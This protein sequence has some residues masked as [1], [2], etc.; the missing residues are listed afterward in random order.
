MRKQPKNLI[1]FC[2]LF[3]VVLGLY[4]GL[5]SFA[6][7][8]SDS[9]KQP[10]TQ[11]STNQLRQY[12]ISLLNLRNIDTQDPSVFYSY[13]RTFAEVESQRKN[14]DTSSFSQETTRLI[15]QFDDYVKDVK[16]IYDP[17][18]KMFEY[19][20]LDDLENPT[21]ENT[22]QTVKDRLTATI[23][24]LTAIKNDSNT[25]SAKST[26]L[27]SQTISCI[28]DLRARDI[29]TQDFGS[30]TEICQST[31]NLMRSSIA[32][33]VLAIIN[34]SKYTTV[35]SDFEQELKR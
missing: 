26:E 23:N 25:L 29:Q 24:A 1:L 10:L 6:S 3:I 17:L 28:E 31:Y 9:T 8:F 19:Q 18:S 7:R 16:E 27:S 21:R 12:Y 30:K 14:L 2:T 22:P 13:S 34:S 5:Y 11:S 4:T 15:N 35:F 32:N 33:D 20:L